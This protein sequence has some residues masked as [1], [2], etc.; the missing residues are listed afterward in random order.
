[1]SESVEERLLTVK[2]VAQY[3]GLHPGTLYNLAS[4]GRGPKRVKIGPTQVR[5][6]ESDVVDYVRE[7]E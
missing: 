1:M 7:E 2:E 3:Y 4:Q 5:Y 6:R